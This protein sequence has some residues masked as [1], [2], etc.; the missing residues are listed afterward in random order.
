MNEAHYFHWDFKAD[1]NITLALMEV[2]LALVGESLPMDD[3]N[4]ER[5]GGEG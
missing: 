3:V 2:T 1:K 4:R 5:Q